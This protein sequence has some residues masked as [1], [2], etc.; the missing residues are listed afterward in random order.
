MTGRQMIKLYKRYGWEV[1]RVRGS[2]YTMKKGSLVERIP[3]H[4]K[5]MKKGLEK[6]LLKRLIEGEK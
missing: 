3:H 2:H 6:K 4:T 1:I 5:E